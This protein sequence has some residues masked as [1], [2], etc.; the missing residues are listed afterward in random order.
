MSGAPGPAVLG[1]PASGPAAP[2]SGSDA[3]CANSEGACPSRAEMGPA[4]KQKAR[5]GEGVG[6]ALLLEELP[7]SKLPGQRLRN[8]ECPAN[9]CACEG[10]RQA[11]NPSHTPCP[12]ATGA[13]SGSPG[14]SPRESSQ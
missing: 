1:M 10:I 2:L 5:S 4:G 13:G 14:L 11:N 12:R 3:V 8:G 6:K 7:S 9:T